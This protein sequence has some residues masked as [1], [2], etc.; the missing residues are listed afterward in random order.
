MTRYRS[1]P[2]PFLAGLLLAIIFASLLLVGCASPSLADKPTG[3]DLS[4][5]RDAAC[6]LAQAV[7]L[8][9]QIDPAIDATTKDRL[10]VAAPFVVAACSPDSSLDSLRAMA[11]RAFPVVIDTV[12]QAP[13]LT[14]EQKQAALVTL[15]TA[16]IVIAQVYRKQ[17]P[18]VA[19]GAQ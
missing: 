10:A 4:D 17:A 1:M 12:M 6:P 19:G 16:R 14:T 18:A 5:L 8:G 9:L 3:Q 11:D 13:T 7:I 15:T 2:L